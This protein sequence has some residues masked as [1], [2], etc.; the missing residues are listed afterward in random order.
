MTQRVHNFNPGPA[1]L[2]LSVLE[3][4]QG[5]L[6]DFA[7]TGM[8]ILEM[9]HR[10]ATYEQLHNQAIADLRTLL[11]GTEDHAIL[12]MGG[13]AQMQFALVALNLLAPG[14]YA[15]YLITGVWS[16][17]ALSEAR[18]IGD[19]RVLWSSALTAHTRI[20]LPGE[21]HIEAGAAYLH[22]TSNNTIVG[23]Q[24]TYVPAARDIP[25]VCDMSSD[26]LSRP[27]DL[28]PYSLIYAGAQK[29]LGPAGV[30]VVLIRHDL[31]ERCRPD[32]PST[33]SY[34]QMAAHNS[35]LNTPPVFA[36]YVAGLVAQ[37]LLAQGGLTAAEARNREKAALLY[38]AIDN[39]EGFY[40]GWAQPESRSY[41]NV[42][43]RLPTP[44]LEKRFITESAQ[45]GLIGLAGHRTVGGMRASLYNAVALEA[46]RT[47]VEF[48]EEF[49]RHH[50]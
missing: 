6:L 16:E 34:A 50:A 14:A 5:D 37:H 49:Q 4:V 10:S 45:A 15:E 48:M 46:V 11:G 43:F 29:N 35:L 18:K 26:L 27:V 40:R 30:T 17:T 1:A 24:Y 12:F 44:A 41:M 47:L 33:M 8:S 28:S 7:G 20:P 2:P 32:L 13:G 25:L 23:T 31:L 38:A 3:Q 22:Y 42:T 21:F 9:S 39:S 19:A 36:I